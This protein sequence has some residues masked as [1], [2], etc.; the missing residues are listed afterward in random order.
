MLETYDEGSLLLSASDEEG[1]LLRIK[2][3]ASELVEFTTG[4]DFETYQMN[5]KTNYACAFALLQ[6]GAIGN[7]IP[8]EAQVKLGIPWRAVS[9]ARNASVNGHTESH[10]RIIFSEI[11]KNIPTLLLKLEEQVKER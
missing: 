4:M 7:R 1:K 10:Q 2:K 5:T 6:I 8:G 9:T 11:E 3:Y